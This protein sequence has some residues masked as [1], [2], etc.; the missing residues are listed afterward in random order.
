MSIDAL[1]LKKTWEDFEGSEVGVSPAARATPLA[2][3]EG[4]SV[5]C[6]AQL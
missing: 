6:S 2:A 5:A 1:G 4:A 3:E